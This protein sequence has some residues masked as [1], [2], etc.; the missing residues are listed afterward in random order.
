RLRRWKRRWNASADSWKRARNQIH[1][2]QGGYAVRRQ[3][4][5]QYK[6]PHFAAPTWPLLPCWRNGI[7]ANDGRVNHW[8]E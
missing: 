6:A 2:G 5:V 3:R 4:P 8:R 1:T 7:I